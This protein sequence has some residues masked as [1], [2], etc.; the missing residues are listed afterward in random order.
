MPTLTVHLKQKRALSYPIVI[1]SGLFK[2]MAE[3]LFK[4]HPRRNYVIVTDLTVKRRHADP[5]AK[6][7]KRKGG[8]VEVFAFKAGEEQK[9]M[10]TVERLIEQMIQADFDRGCLVIAI[11]GG[12]VG[13][14]AGF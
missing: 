7:I 12:V 2:K 10:T 9:N 4:D 1:Q 6:N 11:G 3:R 13:D 8:D 14:V 5:L